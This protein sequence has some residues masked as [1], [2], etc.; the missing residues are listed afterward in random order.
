MYK[1]VS[2][3]HSSR[4]IGIYCKHLIRIKSKA[5]W[6]WQSGNV[7]KKS[8]FLVKIIFDER[9]VLKFTNIILLEHVRGPKFVNTIIYIIHWYV[10]ELQGGNKRSISDKYLNLLNGFSTRMNLCI[11]LKFKPCKIDVFHRLRGAEWDIIYTHQRQKCLFIPNKPLAKMEICNGACYVW[12][13][14]IF[15]FGNIK[16]VH[17]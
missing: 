11:V 6:V 13:Y 2:W 5:L 12:Y 16:N 9:N 17:K 8:S 7:Y 14:F 4:L 10:T 3:K 15:A 1:L